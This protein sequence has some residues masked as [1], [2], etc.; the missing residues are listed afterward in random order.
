MVAA[1][2]LL[3]EALTNKRLGDLK[4]LNTTALEESVEMRLGEY[5]PGRRHCLRVCLEAI[6]LAFADHRYRTIEDFRGGSPLVCSCFGVSE[7]VIE[8]LIEDIGPV[9]VDEI[10]AA[11]HAGSGCGSCRMLIQEMIDGG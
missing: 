4:G 3:A 6:Q 7:D 9:S 2:D 10:T 11:C 1:G 8:Q 5:P